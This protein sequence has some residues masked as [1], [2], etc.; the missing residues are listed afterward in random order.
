MPN[1]ELAEAAAE[2]LQNIAQYTVSQ[3]GAKQVVH[4]GA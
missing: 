4:Y 2:D 1:Y 3:W